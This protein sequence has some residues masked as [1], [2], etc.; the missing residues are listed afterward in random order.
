MLPGRVPD[1][2]PLLLLLLLQVESQVKR[3][4]AMSLL[5]EIPLLPE[6]LSH[7]ALETPLEL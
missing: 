2:L 1:L 6:L 5:L 4:A 7:E 3:L